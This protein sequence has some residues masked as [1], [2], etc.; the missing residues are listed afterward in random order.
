MHVPFCCYQNFSISGVMIVVNF[1]TGHYLVGQKRLSNSLNGYKKLML[2]DYTAI[3]SPSHSESPYQFKVHAIEAAAKFDHVVLWCDSSLWRVG[4]LSK[5][6]K[7]ILEKGYFM[8]ESGHYC[9]DWCKPE[10]KKW[11]K[12]DSSEDHYIMFSA[13]LLG[14]NFDHPD[15]PLW[16][17]A[18]KV[19]AKEGHFKGPWSSHRHDM[20]C[21]SIIAQRMGFKYERGGSH[22][23]YVG[24]GYSK[25]EK[26]T[27]FLL[28]GI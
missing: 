15:I 23:S 27:V 3:G 6:E 9:K 26:D 19:A 11:F 7:I 24:P 28:Q 17:A 16:F 13:G 18:W 2:S 4:D 22:L 21:G 14:L 10:T 5:I 20:V 12:L 25:P 1:A 8:E